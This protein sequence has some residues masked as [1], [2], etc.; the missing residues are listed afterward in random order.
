MQFEKNIEYSQLKLAKIVEERQAFIR[1]V[2]CGSYYALDFQHVNEVVEIP[3]ITPYPET[4]PGHL[5]V[6]NLSGQILPILDFTGEYIKVNRIN[7]LQNSCLL[8]VVTFTKDNPFGL[9]IEHPRRVEAAKKLL[10]SS[11]IN[12]DGLPVRI[13]RQC[14]F[15][16]KEN[17]S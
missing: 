17:E 16:S 10:T 4:I 3:V 11:T 5:G 9:I 6:V 7:S 12:I 14:D 8:L 2:M 13:L 15:D 1:F